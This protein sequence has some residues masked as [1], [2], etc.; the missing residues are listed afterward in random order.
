M[1]NYYH[2]TFFPTRR[3]LRFDSDDKTDDEK[4]TFNTPLPYFVETKSG[5]FVNIDKIDEFHPKDCEIRK[6]TSR[7][8]HYSSDYIEN[9]VLDCEGFKQLLKNNNWFIEKMVGEL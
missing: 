9:T 4:S 6:H 8:R 7:S 3:Y 5:T 1:S 2:N